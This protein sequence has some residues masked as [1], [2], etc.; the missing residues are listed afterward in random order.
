MTTS[1]HR[2]VASD[3]ARDAA[4]ASVVWRVID[5]LGDGPASR[6]PTLTF[7]DDLEFDSLTVVTM[8]AI[9]E[10]L[11]G[12]ELFESDAVAEQSAVGELIAH[13]SE[14]LGA[15]AGE[16]PDVERIDALLAQYA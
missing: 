7:A 15:G 1:D 12:V 8:Y 6:S 14:L 11:F 5:F 3:P 16:L 13:L 4:V 2:S 10:E 9:C